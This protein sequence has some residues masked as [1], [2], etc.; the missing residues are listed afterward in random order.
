[1]DIQ[2]WI[3][4]IVIVITLIARA[5]KKK[6]GQESPPDNYPEPPLPPSTSRQ[7][8]AVTFE[9]LLREIQGQKTLAKHAPAPAPQKQYDFVDYDD[10]IKDEEEDLEDV[11]YD[12]SRDDEVFKTYEAAKKQAFN[13]PSLEEVAPVGE[14][15]RFDHFKEYN[16]PKKKRPSL[17]FLKELK[18]PQGFKKAFIMSEIIKR[19]Y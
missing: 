5:N 7:P 4:I 8:K 19:K 9:D 3:W 6:P 11:D 12:A 13:R 2:F 15:V 1:M 17:G 16:T 10:D 14:V 18:D